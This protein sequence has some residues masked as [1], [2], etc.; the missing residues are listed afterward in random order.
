MGRD[1]LTV[2]EQTRDRIV[3]QERSHSALALVF[4]FLG[5][6]ALAA[7]ANRWNAGGDLTPAWLGLSASGVLLCL[8]LYCLIESTFSV[9]QIKGVFQIRRRIGWLRIDRNYPVDKVNRVFER[10]TGKGAGL[11]LEL[12]SGREKDLTLSTAYFDL[13]GQAGTLN[14]FIQAARKQMR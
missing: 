7:S 13:S 3:L 11:R 5:M 1:R 10:H 8:G 9:G 4:L 14:Q 2:L 6:L 12:T